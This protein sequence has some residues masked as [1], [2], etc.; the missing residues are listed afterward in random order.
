MNK[1]QN[2]PPGFFNEEVN[3]LLN[4]YETLMDED[5]KKKYDHDQRYSDNIEE[6]VKSATGDGVTATSDPNSHPFAGLITDN[7]KKEDKRF[8]NMNSEQLHWAYKMC[9]GAFLIV[10]VPKGLYWIYFACYNS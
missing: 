1:Y 7:T 5:L 3:H 4:A 10:F 2:L 8:T 9:L 6:L